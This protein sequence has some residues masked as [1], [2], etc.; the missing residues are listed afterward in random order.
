MGHPKS[1]KSQD[2]PIEIHGTSSNDAISALQEQVQNIM[3]E[4]GK[5]KKKRDKSNSSGSDSDSTSFSSDE[6]H[7]ESKLM[8]LKAYDKLKVPGLPKSAAELRTW[9]NGLIS[10]LVACCRSS[11]HELLTWLVKP[12]EGEEIPSDE[13]PVLNRV[14]GSKILDA[15][16]GTR[17]SIDFQA[18]QERS[19][20][21]GVQVQGHML[22]AKICKKFRLDKE[23]GMS[24]SQQHLLA[25]KPQGNEIKDLEIFR[26]RVEFVLSG[27]E[28]SD[29][30]A[31][32]ILRTWIYDCLKSIPRMSLRVDKY[33][34]ASVGSS[35]RSFQF[36]WQSMIE[37]IDEAQYDQNATSILSTLKVKVDAAPGQ[38]N[39]SDKKKNDKKE[40]KEKKDKGKK[41]EDK[42][43]APVAPNPKPKPK[44][45]KPKAK[46]EDKG[47]ADP[48]GKA[49][50]KNEVV[51]GEKGVPCIFYPSGT[52]RRDPCPY[53]H[54]KEAQP[55]PK[56][57]AKAAAVPIVP[58]AFAL[59]SVF[60]MGANAVKSTVSSFMPRLFKTVVAAT[61]AIISPSVQSMTSTVPALTGSIESKEVPFSIFDPVEE[62][63]TWLGDTGAGRTIGCVK[64]VPLDC[65]GDASK[66]V[67]FSTGGGRRTGGLSCKVTGEF[68]GETECY[69]LEQSP[70]ALSIGEQV[71]NG[72]AFIWTPSDDANG[73][74][75][76]PFMVSQENVHM[77]KVKIP[78]RFR[79]YADEVR[80]N[81]PLFRE[82]VSVSHMPAELGPSLKD[83]KGD[84]DSGYSPSSVG[85]PEEIVEDNPSGEA[86]GRDSGNAPPEI[87][88]SSDDPPKDKKSD[89]H[90][91]LHLPK[92]KKCAVCQEAKQDA[93][94][95][96][97]VKG[98]HVMTDGKPSEKFGDRIH[99]DHI[100][101]AKNRLS[102]EKKGIN[103]ETVCL[104]LYDDFTK[105]ICAYPSNS[106]STENC[107]HAV[108]KFIGS[109]SANELHS[110]NAPELEACARKIGLVPDPTVPYRKT[111]VINRKIRT[112]EDCTRC[113]LVQVGNHSSL[114]P[115][116]IEYSASAMTLEVWNKIHDHDFLG[117]TFPFGSLVHYRPNVQNS[118]LG[119]KTS[120]GLFLGWRLESG[121]NWKG[122]Y[123]VADLTNVSEWL[124]GKASLTIITTMTVVAH[125]DGTS[126]PL[127]I[128]TQRQIEQLEDLPKLLEDS[129]IEEDLKE[130]EDEPK[131]SPS[132]HE[133]GESSGLDRHEKI[134]FDRF[135]EFGPTPNCTA[136]QEGLQNHTKECR[137]RFDKLI[138]ESKFE[139]PDGI[140]SDRDSWK[141]D[142]NK[143][144]R[145]HRIKRKRLFAPTKTFELPIPKERIGKR[146][147]RIR[148]E[149]GGE[150]D[151]I[152][153]EE[154][155]G[156]TKALKGWWT[157]V[158]IFEI[159][160]EDIPVPVG[161]HDPTSS[162]KERREKVLKQQVSEGYGIFIECC[163]DP[164]SGLGAVSGRIGVKHIRMTEDFGNLC[165]ENVVN[166]LLDRLKEPEYAGVDLWGS[167]PC[168]PWTNWQQ[169]N[170]YGG[171][172]SLILR[173]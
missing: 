50:P 61:A 117:L 81:V 94:P 11:E 133:A 75:P 140:P 83:D 48:K 30:P 159:L 9:K 168:K 35:Q 107:I 96:R 13:F 99:G 54:D 80:E 62:A 141:V 126:F 143:L 4:L 125:K 22:I 19:V 32:S 108:N 58:S 67:S 172:E 1:G 53:V 68:T 145:Y 90:D 134:T 112:L 160:G 138:R 137:E 93:L 169:M 20:R 51:A 76:K 45:G 161:V 115:L 65:V 139:F 15:A 135:V 44:G 105:A 88:P 87:K 144:I 10:Q 130:I 72:K 69:L 106:K 55:K 129:R 26:D 41:K 2:D 71:K 142:G 25:L 21:N 82:K 118:K 63:V 165:D 116:A 153:A 131:G 5:R 97:R 136:C 156:N 110:D 95:A 132:Q 100:I 74:L 16:K 29:Y 124:S 77:L 34:E 79:R 89:S 111:A 28:T 109:R 166:Q 120:P 155:R 66:P 12:F 173:S 91:I 27:L 52:C 170:I 147:T 119:A 163:C 146:V 121:V 36:L 46:P 127:R 167:L 8:R 103:G 158:S 24:L 57:K 128:A 43:A 152:E 38:P 150:H 149:E 60:P 14:I 171:T 31:E 92:D 6:Y 40:K 148:F 162:K 101:V 42:P 3:D 86:L 18:L 56:P 78:E 37:I 151:S 122:V 47:Q 164:N 157:G 98:P 17:F 154:W 123:K 102:S 39:P 23:K 73:E 85:D 113:C 64:Q 59:S 84:K 104:V 70:W 49:S 7:R 33:R 114:W